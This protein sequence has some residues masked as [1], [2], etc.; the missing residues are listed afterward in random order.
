MLGRTE[1][2]DDIFISGKI[3]FDGISASNLAMKEASRLSEI[4][5]KAQNVEI[6]EDRKGLTISYLNVRSLRNKVTEIMKT[7]SLMHSNVFGLGETWLKSDENVQI[8]K[9]KSFFASYGKGKGVAVY[10]QND[11]FDEPLAI[12][13]D[14]FSMIVF[15]HKD[16]VA[17]FL[18]RSQNCDEVQLCSVLESV[19][20]GNVPI[21]VMGDM[22][23]DSEKKSVLHNYLTAKGFT[24]EI[25]MPTCDTGSTLD[26]LY[27]NKE[28]K[29]L[30]FKIKQ[31]PV[32]YSDH[33]IIG[34]QIKNL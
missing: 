30:S 5:E 19:M 10:S 13:E 22:N 25:K 34:L 27:V 7:S 2:L 1:R 20:K 28:M 11:P 15:N 26:H 17:M 31:N 12:V 18:Y 33:D 29:S 8:D 4:F 21:V 23:I 32:Y 9:F 14:L 3:D 6:E 24:Q 16:F